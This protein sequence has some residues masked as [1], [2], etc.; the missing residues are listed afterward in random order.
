MVN[1]SPIEK[2]DYVLGF[3]VKNPSSLGYALGRAC[4]LISEEKVIDDRRLIEQIL[5]KL[6]KD[7]YLKAEEHYS[8]A[9][10]KLADSGDHY[11]LT[12]DGEAF[13]EQGGY[14]A[15]SFKNEKTFK[16][17]ENDRKHNLKVADNMEANAKRL[18]R[19]TLWLAVGTGALAIIE[20]IKLIARK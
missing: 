7:G 6:V 20:I 19:L 17:I 14:K 8:F 15:E 1:L 11:L 10:E 4:I 12:F 2:L 5:T 13:Y 16:L 3:F 9:G 18:N